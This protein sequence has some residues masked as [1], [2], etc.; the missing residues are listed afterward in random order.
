MTEPSPDELLAGVAEALQETVL[1]D[2]ERGFGRNQ[3]MAAIGIVGRCSEAVDRYGP[4]LYAG[5]VDLIATLRETTAADPS[6]LSDH[7]R[8]DLADLLRRSVDVL[9]SGYPPPSALAGLHS[10]L[11]EHLAA[12]LLAGQQGESGQMPALRELLR[13][14]SDREEQIGLSPW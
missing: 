4:T 3:V 7:A 12:I 5:C 14:I 10:E 6:L 1:P 9:D 13:R 2:L 8:D 11:T